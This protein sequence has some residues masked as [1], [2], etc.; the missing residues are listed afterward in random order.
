MLLFGYTFGNLTPF[1]RLAMTT[2]ESLQPHLL[3][4]S[5]K[6]CEQSNALGNLSDFSPKGKIWDKHRA[7][8]D[9]ISGYY[10]EGGKGN[11]YRYAQRVSSCSEWLE[12]RLVPELAEGLLNLKL[13]STRFCR[14][15]H[16]PVCQWRRSL[17]WKA[18]AYKII[19]QVVADYPKY[20]WLFITL[21]V[22]NCKIEELRAT[23]DRINRAFKRL[24]E[25]KAWK[26]L[27]WVKS[28]EVTRGR[29]QLS[30]H[31]HL[32]ILAM[33]Q[34]SYFSHGYISQAKWVDLWQKCLRSDYK[35]V[36]HVK[37]IAKQHDPNVII[38]EILKYQVKESDLIGDP[39][40]FLE[41]TRQ[42]HKTRAVAVGGVL[43]KYIRELESGQNLISE[44][45][46]TN[47]VDEGSLYFRWKRELKKY[48]REE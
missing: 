28:V 13:S 9:I 15:R 43:R 21:T 31:P 4:S 47:E 5:Q 1:H 17:M 7:N 40:W 2:I 20:R 33:V 16:C 14:V 23:L 8:S 48:K 37:A 27:G 3:V 42:L 41:L 38:P 30:A 45:E 36:I 25:L 10:A 46:E 11:F 44:D 29:D 6:K 39:Q 19:P 24:T 26:A 35:P 12:F 18:K 22:K 34:P 32:H